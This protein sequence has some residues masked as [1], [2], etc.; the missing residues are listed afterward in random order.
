M[1][2]K[3]GDIPWNKGKV[4]VYSTEYRKKI[5]QS[6]IGKSKGTASTP[7]KEIER[8]YKISKTMRSNPNAGG[9][10]IR[11][12]RGK[13]GWYGGYWCDSSW[14]LAWVIYHLDHEIKFTRN[15]VGFEYVYNNQ[16]HLYYP[17]YVIN[18]T[19][20]E[21]K[22]RRTYKDLDEKNKEKINQFGKKL[23]VLYYNEIKPYLE[24]TVSKYGKDFIKLYEHGECPNGRGH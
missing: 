1:P 12:G 20:Y 3:K 22:G 16:K 18:D 14:E 7:E 9:L 10:R 6:L 23:Y 8:R 13:K 17:D 2:I 24:Y 19:Y 11:S 21:I 4:G 15:W 5:S